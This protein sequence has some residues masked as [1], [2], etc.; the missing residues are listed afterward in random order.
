MVME[1]QVEVF[2]T[3]V[4]CSDVV[5]YRYLWGPCCFLLHSEGGGNKVL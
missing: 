2:Q 1:I 4:P 5:E 3:V